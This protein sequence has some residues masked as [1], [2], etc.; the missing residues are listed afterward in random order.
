MDNRLKFIKNKVKLDKNNIKEENYVKKEIE[1]SILNNEA[2][3]EKN[4]KGILFL[5]NTGEVKVLN[6]EGKVFSTG[7]TFN[8]TPQNEPSGIDLVRAS[9]RVPISVRDSFINT[10]SPATSTVAVPPFHSI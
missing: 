4:C 8:F 5:V 1:K 2:F 6:Q 10:F 3:N 9:T 7:L